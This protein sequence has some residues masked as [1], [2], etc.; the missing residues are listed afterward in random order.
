MGRPRA[1]LA[2]N[3]VAVVVV[4]VVVAVI[5]VAIVVVDMTPEV[6]DEEDLSPTDAVLFTPVVIPLPPTQ[7]VKKQ[8][9]TN[10]RAV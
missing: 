6:G 10:K 3:V 5:E 1:F 9:Q 7:T 8:K 4:V 2:T